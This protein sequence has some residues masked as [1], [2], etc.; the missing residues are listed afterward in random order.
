MLD[1]KRWSVR[2]FCTTCAENVALQLERRIAFRRAMKRAVQTT[3]SMGAEVF[4]SNVQVAWVGLTS[5]VPS[6]SAL[7]KYLYKPFVQI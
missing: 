4:V 1:I 5:H 7:E 3:M 6:N 2:I